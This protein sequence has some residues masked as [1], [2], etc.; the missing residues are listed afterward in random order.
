MSKWLGKNFLPELK[1]DLEEGFVDKVITSESGTDGYM[2]TL[3]RKGYKHQ[4]I[5]LLYTNKQVEQGNLVNLEI[6]NNI[7]QLKTE[8][9]YIVS[10][11]NWEKSSK[12]Y[13]EEEPIDI[14]QEVDTITEYKELDGHIEN[15]EIIN[16]FNEKTEDTEETKQK[17]NS[18]MLNKIN[19]F[20]MLHSYETLPKNL[21]EVKDLLEILT[22]EVWFVNN[23]NL[24]SLTGEKVFIES[25][26]GEFYVYT[27]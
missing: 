10:G 26:E 5:H 18:H 21:I 16:S 1:S 2:I 24:E 27:R 13:Q 23:N 12:Y 17:L 19:G 14:L 20:M 6:Y 7:K 8:V 11:M 9:K 4:I 25:E 3:V 22:D 15:T